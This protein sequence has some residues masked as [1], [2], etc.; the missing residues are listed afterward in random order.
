MKEFETKTLAKGKDWKP[1]FFLFIRISGWI[2]FPVIFALFVG[3]WLDRVFSTTPILFL[4]LTGI[5]FGI[6]LFG[7]IKESRK[8]MEQIINSSAEVET[9]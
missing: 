6:S 9:K 8:T 5:A 7:I 1:A 4:S 2:T 3:K